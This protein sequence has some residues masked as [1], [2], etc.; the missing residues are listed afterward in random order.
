MFFR[1]FMTFQDL[2]SAFHATYKKHQ[3]HLL[4]W[5]CFIIYDVF[6]S[7]LID[8]FGQPGIYI[9][10][11]TAAISVFYCHAYL[12]GFVASR[13]NNSIAFL[14]AIV[15]ITSELLGYLCLVYLLRYVFATLNLVAVADHT[16]VTKAFVL[17]NIWRALYFVG[18]GTGYFYILKSIDN[19]K[20]VEEFKR[21]SLIDQI[22]RHSLENSLIQTQNNYLRSQINPHFL[23]NTLN[24]IYNDARKKAPIAAEAI[25]NL[26]E[27]MRY[28]LKR[29]EAL[30]IVPITEEIAQIE[31]LIDLHKLRTKNAINLEF[32]IEGELMGVRFPPLILLTLVENMFKHGNI[33]HPTQPAVIRMKR[34]QNILEINFFNLIGPTQQNND[35]CHKVGVI[36][37]KTRLENIYK[38]NCVFNCFTDTQKQTYR[39]EISVNLDF[40]PKK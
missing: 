34:N 19:T 15:V 12:M 31:H 25:M 5:G 16:S 27:M 13:K 33:L 10:S 7:G 9:I 3:I 23:F 20:T 40:T 1:R 8:R 35:N 6:I 21:K 28:A 22:E 14:V 11:F 17:N 24:F 30:E 39:T 26:S 29:S 2:I 37:T 36:N 32:I 4:A 38:S 18:F